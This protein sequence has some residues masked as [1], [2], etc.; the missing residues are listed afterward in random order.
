MRRWSDIDA[1]QPLTVRTVAI[2]R[3]VRLQKLTASL[4]ESHERG[5]LV[6]V[7]GRYSADQTGRAQP[8]KIAI[9]QVGWTSGRIP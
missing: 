4:R 2:P 6:T 1:I 7:E 3:S 5:P 9:P 8:L